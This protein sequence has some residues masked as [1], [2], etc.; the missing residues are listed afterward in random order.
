MVWMPVSC[1]LTACY[2]RRTTRTSSAHSS[3][4][5]RAGQKT[6]P[7]ALLVVILIPPKHAHTSVTERCAPCCQ[8]LKEQEW[9]DEWRPPARRRGVTLSM[10]L[11]ANIR[12]TA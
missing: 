1:R 9:Q 12:E 3:P 5:A 2:L 10:N 11:R 4:S 8:L 7:P 6:G